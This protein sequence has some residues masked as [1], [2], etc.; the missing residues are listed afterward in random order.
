MRG[1]LRR[2]YER[3]GRQTIQEL[4]KHSYFSKTDW[5]FSNAMELM[6]ELLVIRDTDKR[7]TL[8]RELYFYDIQTSAPRDRIY[9]PLFKPLPDT[10]EMAEHL[11]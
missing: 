2:H 7:Q 6:E 1:L 9:F 8:W 11:K 10:A 5:N 4:K 3:A